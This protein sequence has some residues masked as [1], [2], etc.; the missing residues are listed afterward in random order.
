[1]PIT[2]LSDLFFFFFL[3]YFILAIRSPFG[4]LKN[5]KGFYLRTCL[6]TEHRIKFPQ[7]VVKSRMRPKVAWNSNTCSDFVFLEIFIKSQERATIFNLLHPFS[8]KKNSNNN[9]Q[10]MFLEITVNFWITT[11]FMGITTIIRWTL[12]KL[13]W[14]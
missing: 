11:L 5:F 12:N 14:T 13:I 2:V 1:M 6:H 4:K 9:N 7:T 10:I 3:C 8:S